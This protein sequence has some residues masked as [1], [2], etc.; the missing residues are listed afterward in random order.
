MTEKLQAVRRRVAMTKGDYRTVGCPLCPV[1]FR[2]PGSKI[3]RALDRHLREVHQ[4]DLARVLEQLTKM[5]KKIERSLS[6]LNHRKE[7]GI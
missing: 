1:V 7:K 5:A 4:T 3:L 2:Y 6:E